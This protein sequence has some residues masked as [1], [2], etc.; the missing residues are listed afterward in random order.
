MRS[1][2]DLST[3]STLDVQVVLLK[4]VKSNVQKRGQVN[5][6][7]VHTK[8]TSLEEFVLVD[9]QKSFGPVTKLTN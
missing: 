6:I 2:N 4:H 9:S 7:T 8:V 5:L 1:C 3:N